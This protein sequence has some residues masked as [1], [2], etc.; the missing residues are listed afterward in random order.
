MVLV[1]KRHG[2]RRHKKLKA[3][4]PFYSGPRK[5]LV[6]KKLVGANQAPRKGEKVDHKV[7]HRFQQFL[8]NK[9]HSEDL[10]KSSKK[11]N[12][13]KF[14]QDTSEKEIEYPELE[15]KTNE[16]DRNYIQRLD[17]EAKFALNRAR[18]E[19]KYDVKLVNTDKNDHHQ[20]EVKKE[21]SQRAEK[22]LKRL[23][24]KKDDQKLK[25]EEKKMKNDEFHLY[26]DKPQF[27]EIVHEPPTLTLPKRSRVDPAKAG[28][29]D[30]L[31]KNKLQNLK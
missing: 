31:L 29:K 30:L 6:D 26:Q 11:K 19:S 3:I 5:L 12:K 27:G 24:T 2:G 7:S 22:R 9:Q 20:F 17:E 1:R 14:K 4:D 8:E 18:Y 15:Q 28:V 21:K 25:K 10:R 23:Q 16:S 13:N